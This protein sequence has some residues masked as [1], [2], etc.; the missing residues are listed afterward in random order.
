MYR[1]QA[2]VI[3]TTVQSLDALARVY[4]REGGNADSLISQLESIKDYAQDYRLL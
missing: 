1:Q 2:E 3:G 4:E